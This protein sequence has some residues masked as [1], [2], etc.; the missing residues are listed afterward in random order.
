MIKRYYLLLLLTVGL[1]PCVHAQN[2]YEDDYRTFDGGL[3]GGFNFTQVDGDSYA[4]YHKTGFNFGGIV[5]AHLGPELAASM[6][7]LY[8]QKGSRGHEVT[9][10]G[11]PGIFI[12]KYR[13][14][15][16]Y[17]EVP[18]QLNYFLDKR[19]SHV[20][21]GLSY[22]RVTSVKETLETNPPTT[23]NLDN[24]PINKS[25]LNL[26]LGGN[27]RVWEGLYLNLRFQYSLIPIRK[28]IP[29][30][31]GRGE[32]YNNVVAIRFMYLF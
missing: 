12:N 23:V 10:S 28:N 19:K 14:D 2:Y 20:G 9:E 15:M 17:V 8:V 24:Y 3:V 16:N 7:I 30:G 11:S 18:I 32:Q 27:L 29:P 4:G 25:D 6:E 5:Y 26:V 22:S 21:A 31:F 13:I 1:V